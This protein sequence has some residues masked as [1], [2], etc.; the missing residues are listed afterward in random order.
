MAT[1]S[2]HSEEAAWS[3]LKGLVDGTIDAK[4]LVLDFSDAEWAQVHFNFKGEDFNQ[5]VTSSVMKGLIAYQ[6]AFNRAVALIL[7]ADA[8]ANRLTHDERDELELVFHVS[9]G[10]SDF[11]A[12]GLE[13]LKTIGE[14]AV[15]KMTGKEVAI[16][17][18][19]LA[20]VF[21]GGYTLNNYIDR[22]YEDAKDAR[23][24]E[25]D[26][27]QKKDLYEF[28]LKDRAAEN[29]KAKILE[30]AIALSEEA[31]KVSE[32]NREA[33]DKLIRS[34]SGAD[35][36]TIQGDVIDNELITSLVKGS[37]STAKDIIIEDIFVVDAV[38]SDDVERF[39]VRLKN[40]STGDIITASLDDPLVSETAQKAISRA[41][42]QAS[43]IKVR[44]SA[45][46]V[47]NQIKDAQIIK[48]FKP[49]TK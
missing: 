48:A 17:A 38:I 25:M 5:T 42:W 3:T 26:R 45:R 24:I 36:I 39:T 4:D 35:A 40:V 15:D 11:L 44:M 1:V 47:G 22:Q 23:Q 6:E 46:K 19:V 37:R 32:M 12:N 10:S 21:M 34:N 20:L 16:T 8:K 33:I 30:K 14:K 27:G 49:R 43:E 31:R 7:T 18:V 28:L 41:Q 13:Q 9:E 29:E 2:I